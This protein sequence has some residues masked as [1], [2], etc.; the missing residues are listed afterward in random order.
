M[1]PGGR[2][3]LR[4]PAIMLCD[5]ICQSIIVNLAVKALPA[6]PQKASFPV[7]LHWRRAVERQNFARE[8]KAPGNQYARRRR[9]IARSEER[10]RRFYAV[11][12]GRRESA[13]ICGGG[14]IGSGLG[15]L[16]GVDG[17]GKNFLSKAVEGQKKSG[18]ILGHERT[19][20]HNERPWRSFFEFRHRLRERPARV[21]IVP[22]VDP[23][24]RTR[25]GKNGHASLDKVLQSGRPFRPRHSY[26]ES[27]RW[28]AGFDRSKRSNCRCGVLML[29]T[30]RKARQRQI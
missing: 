29:V 3:P 19:A 15:I 1:L 23:D 22:A 13:G 21:C 16:V 2:K 18:G 28:K 12:D 24:L 26:L 14:D 27:N 6:A 30:A 20:D 5:A 17:N 10:K 8:I 4:S 11:A 9:P 7:C 25:G